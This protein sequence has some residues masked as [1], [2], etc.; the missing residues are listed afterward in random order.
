MTNSERLWGHRHLPLEP[1]LGTLRSD[2]E[3]EQSDPV[4]KVQQAAG[5]ATGGRSRATRQPG[6]MPLRLGDQGV[7]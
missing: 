7:H 1:Q 3:D 6:Q 2:M 5:G 4:G